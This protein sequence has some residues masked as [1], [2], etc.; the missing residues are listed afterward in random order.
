MN[1][2]KI[3]KIK[4]KSM[5]VY[6]QGYENNTKKE[7]ASRLRNRF[8]S[9]SYKYSSFAKANVSSAIAHIERL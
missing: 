3:Y 8:D 1:T 2:D 7:E 6:A 5:E 4:T 9:S